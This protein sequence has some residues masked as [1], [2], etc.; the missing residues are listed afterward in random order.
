MTDTPDATLLLKK[1]CEGDVAARE[2]FAPLLH[3]ELRK[4]ARHH[5]DRERA[6][7][8]LNPT[9]LV[10]DAWLRLIRPDAGDWASRRQ[11]Y[12]LASRMMRTLLVD[13]A[14]RRGAARR[15]GG[16]RALTLSGEPVAAATTGIDVLLLDE[17]LKRLEG[18]DP[19]LSQIAEMRLF[20]GTEMAEVAA[21]FGLPLRTAERRWTAARVWLQQ[22]LGDG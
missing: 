19:Q 8:T 10:H 7:H 18:L 4:L 12:A 13:H 16:V 2:Q 15:G 17:A 22:E 6:N 9:E 1:L 20:A 3:R 14:R 21:Q 11:F 5:L